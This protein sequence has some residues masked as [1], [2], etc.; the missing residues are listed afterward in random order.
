M[1][2]DLIIVRDWTG[3]LL[4][5]VDQDPG[6]ANPAAINNKI[7]VSTFKQYNWIDRISQGIV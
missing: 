6:R 4:I 1:E 3:N 5:A 7:I 2:H